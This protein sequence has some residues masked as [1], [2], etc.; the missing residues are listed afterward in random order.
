MHK[1][2][3][4]VVRQLQREGFVLERTRKHWRLTSP[5]GERTVVFSSTPGDVR[6][7]DNLKRQLA[8]TNGP[9]C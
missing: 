6:A 1:D 8:G 5:D 2:V 3:A 7:V 9:R 4:K